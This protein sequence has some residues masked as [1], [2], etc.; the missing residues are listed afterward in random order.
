MPSPQAVEAFFN[1]PRPQ[2]NLATVDKIELG[3]QYIVFA[4]RAARDG[5]LTKATAE[6]R[7]QLRDQLSQVAGGDA[8]QA[9]VKSARAKYQI[10]VAEDR[11]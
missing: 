11:L 7:K 8:Q 10:K 3:G 4:I 5:D 1:A 6:E 2:D 9:Y